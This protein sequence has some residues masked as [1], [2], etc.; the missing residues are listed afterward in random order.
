MPGFIERCDPSLHERAPVGSDWVYE[1]KTDGY[2]AQAHL[3]RG[4]IENRYRAYSTWRQWGWLSANDVR[5]REDMNRIDG[6]DLYLAPVN[7]ASNAEDFGVDV[8]VA[9]ERRPAGYQDYGEQHLAEE[10]DDHWS[11]PS[12]FR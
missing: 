8:F 12:L 7:M 3:L 10:F 11:L 9:S 5:E 2:R 4:D 1:I 6:V